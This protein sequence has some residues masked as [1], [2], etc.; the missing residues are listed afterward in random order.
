MQAELLRLYQNLE[1]I[2]DEDKRAGKGYQFSWKAL[3]ESEPP[4][5][6]LKEVLIIR[7]KL[8]TYSMYV[9]LH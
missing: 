9:I 7:E 4:A 8:K 1:D 3:Q 6:Q 2:V 5:H